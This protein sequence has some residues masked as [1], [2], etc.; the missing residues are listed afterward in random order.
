M[1]TSELKVNVPF[2]CHPATPCTQ[3]C[4]SEVVEMENASQKQ[5]GVQESSINSDLS[6]QP[7][8]IVITHL[9]MAIFSIQ[10]T[11]INPTAQGRKQELLSRSEKHKSLD[12]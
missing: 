4:L 2:L 3:D 5:L 1:N 12:D 7:P 6:P 10:R 9:S 8:F 11:K